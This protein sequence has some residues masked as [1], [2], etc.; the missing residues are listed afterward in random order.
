MCAHT[1]AA[2]CLHCGNRC[3]AAGERNSRC[4]RGV[5]SEQ[6]VSSSVESHLST[7]RSATGKNNIQQHLWLKVLSDVQ[8][9][10]EIFK[11]TG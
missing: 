6:G 11:F 8:I 7:D 9:K 10:M 1:D 4:R 3:Q 2:G 5:G